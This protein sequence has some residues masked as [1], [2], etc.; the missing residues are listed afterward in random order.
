MTQSG[1]LYFLHQ[2]GELSLSGSRT[3]T[4]QDVFETL[5]GGRSSAIT[6]VGLLEVAVELA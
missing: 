4:A 6:L 3:K 2:V 1:K 5:T